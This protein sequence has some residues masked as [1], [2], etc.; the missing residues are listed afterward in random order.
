MEWS[1]GSCS[2]SQVLLWKIQRSLGLSAKTKVVLVHNGTE[3]Y[4][5]SYKKPNTPNDTFDIWKS[6]ICHDP[7]WW[8]AKGNT[9][10]FVGLLGNGPKFHY[11]SSQYEASIL[12]SKKQV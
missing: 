5:L 6:S 2:S 8:R 3:W 1:W 12:Y 7:K 4:I 9:S 11:A 10:F